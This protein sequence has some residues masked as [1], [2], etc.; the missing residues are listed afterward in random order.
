MG[1]VVIGGGGAGGGGQQQNRV[2]GGEIVDTSG[3]QVA[4]FPDSAE[5]RKN[6]IRYL[7]M[8]DRESNQEG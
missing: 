5:G 4:V 3:Q 6:A 8:L 1:V 7:K 2:E